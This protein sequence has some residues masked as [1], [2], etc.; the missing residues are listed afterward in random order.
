MRKKSTSKKQGSDLERLSALTDAEIDTSAVPEISPEQFARAVVRRGLKP[1][2]V[3]AQLTIRVDREV[4]D[5]F[6]GQ[7]RGYQTRINALLRAYMEA[8]KKDVA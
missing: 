5:W 7:G 3:K 2:P 4:L 8:H 1:V 6:R